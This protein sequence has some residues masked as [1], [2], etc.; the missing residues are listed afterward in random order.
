[1]Q[2]EKHE[3]LYKIASHLSRRTFERGGLIMP[4]HVYIQF[5]KPDTLCKLAAGSYS[6]QYNGVRYITNNSN[7]QVQEEKI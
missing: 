1:M 5:L 3:A 7:N 2:S 6:L 4:P